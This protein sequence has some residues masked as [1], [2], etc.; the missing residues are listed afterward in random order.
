M[1]KRIL[2]AIDPD[3]P[4]TFAAFP[5]ASLLADTCGAELIVCSVI[6]DTA[7][8]F[9]AGL[10]QMGYR[11]LIDTARS[12]LLLIAGKLLDREVPVEI[13][14]G[15][16]ASGILDIADNVEADLIVLASHRPG[17]K[18]HLLTAHGARIARRATCSVLVVRSDVE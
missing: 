5:P 17:P 4:R 15:S 10:T 14:A 1:F 3:E 9:R 11:E 12:K 13:G 8:M 7:V 16:V 6:P 18:D 2:I